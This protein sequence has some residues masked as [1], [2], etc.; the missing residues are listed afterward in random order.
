MAVPLVGLTGALGAGKSTA[1]EQLAEL[2]AE[3]LS[4]DDVVH[5]LYTTEQVAEAVRGHFGDEVFDGGRVDRRALG[6][7][8]FADDAD[9]RWLE[10][11]LWPLV[12][13]RS[14]QFYAR[15]CSRQPPPPAAVVEAPLLFEA[16]AQSRFAATIAVVADDALRAQRIAGRDQ[17]ALASRESRQLPQREKARLAT[18]VVVNDGTVAELRAQLAEVLEQLRR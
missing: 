7:R 11:L 18:Y 5:D 4:A 17:A 8:A 10:Q 13:E 14:A 12:A 6:A 9:R 16:G 1:L 2:G 15:A 3:V